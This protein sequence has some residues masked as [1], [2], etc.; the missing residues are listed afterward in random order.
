MLSLTEEGKALTLELHRRV[1]AYE[2]RLCEGVSE[3]GDGEPSPPS[4][5]RS[6][7]TTP[8]WNSMSLVKH[9]VCT[10]SNSVECMVSTKLGLAVFLRSFN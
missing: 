3:D 2:A 4:P 9:S 10:H 5:P 7:P 8:P 6:R 1:Q